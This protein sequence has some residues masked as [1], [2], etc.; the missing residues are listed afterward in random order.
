LT[1]AQ[2]TS[3]VIFITFTLVN[4]ALI[5]IKLRDPHPQGIRTYPIII[6]IIAVIL[7]MTLLGIQVSTLF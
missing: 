7:N 1:L 6:P 3:F 2:S 5:R 4:I